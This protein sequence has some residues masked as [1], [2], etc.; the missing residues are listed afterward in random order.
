MGLCVDDVFWVCVLLGFGCLWFA[1]FVL[2]LLYCLM[3]GGFGC[4]CIDTVCVSFMV[5]CLVLVFGLVNS[6]D[7]VYTSF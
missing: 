1:G 3:G 4:C 7:I 2:W 5:V 6:V